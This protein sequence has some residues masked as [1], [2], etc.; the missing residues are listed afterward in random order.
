MASFLGEIGDILTGGLQTALDLEIAERLARLDAPSTAPTAPPPRG[1]TD[2]G[3]ATEDGRV[4]R[5]GEPSGLLAQL[6]QSPMLVY[7]V[8]GGALLLVVLLR[9]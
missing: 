2:R 4:I 8:L 9:R 7:A 5:A 1:D 3:I 6:Q